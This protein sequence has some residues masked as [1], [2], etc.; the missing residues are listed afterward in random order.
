MDTNEKLNLMMERFVHPNS[1]FAQQIY[2]SE[3]KE[4]PDGSIRNAGTY[5]F[6]V[7]RGECTHTPKHTRMR[8]CSDFEDLTFNRKFLRQHLMGIKTYAPYQMS[9]DGKVK[10]LTFD[11]DS[12]SDVTPEQ[13][14]EATISVVKRVNKKLGKG[15]CL[16]EHSGSKGYHVW[17]F[18]SKPIDVGYAFALGHDLTHDITLMHDINIEVY[19]KQ[20]SNTRTFGNTIKI[21]LGVHQKT[22]E[23]CF[24]VNANF[25]PHEDQW[26]VLS[27]VQL[28]D[29]EWVYKNVK[30]VES[31]NSTTMNG[32]YKR[33]NPLC[34]VEVMEEGC[35]EGLR[36]EATFRIANYFHSKDMPEYM[37][38]DSINAW[39]RLNDPPLE[40]DVID[41]KI[42][43]AYKS[44]YPWKPCHLPVWD[45]HCHS[46]CPFFER[47]VEKRWFTKDESPVGKISRD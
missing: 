16:V 32:E 28:V 3:N 25:E 37:A 33:Y 19:P 22:G 4:R 36:D 23:R 46:S 38:R 26:K 20:Q 47:K 40:E 17:I 44:D 13:I 12:Y 9:E 18:F 2:Y 21:P 5:Y 30:K 43:S 29:P 11:L 45:H 14:Q 10:Y 15:H 31:K 1:K 8:E 7:R 6:P 42:E 24:F 27:D 41:I 34:L 39:N 35:N